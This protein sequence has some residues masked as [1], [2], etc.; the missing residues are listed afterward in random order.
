MINYEDI[1]DDQY[2][3]LLR[4]REICKVGRK[5]L[6][7]RADEITNGGDKIIED[8]CKQGY[9]IDV[10]KGIFK[11]K[12][13][14]FLSELKKKTYEARN[15]LLLSEFQNKIR[16]TQTELRDIDVRINELSS[17]YDAVCYMIDEY[18]GHKRLMLK[19]KMCEVILEDIGEC[20]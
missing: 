5:A 11:P 4:Q 13:R 14:F 17:Q 18:E 16:Q 19:D 9:V 15:M 7:N 3:E 1:N 6:H 20:K 2:D 8:L 10:D 12:H